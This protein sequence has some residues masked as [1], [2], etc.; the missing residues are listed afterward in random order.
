[1]ASLPQAIREEAISPWQAA[2]KD[3]K[4]QLQST[5][6][7]EPPARPFASAIAMRLAGREYD[8]PSRHPSFVTRV[9][10]VNITEV[11]TGVYKWGVLF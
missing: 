1:M 3:P 11:V 5:T 7:Q 4:R 6:V 10:Y 9:Y 2:R 8:S